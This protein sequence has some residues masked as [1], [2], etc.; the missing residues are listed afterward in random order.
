LKFW[1]FPLA[2]GTTFFRQ[3]LE[4]RGAL[5]STK[6]SET[7]ET[8]TNGTEISLESFRKSKN[9]RISE[10]GTIQPKIQEIPEGK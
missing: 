6:N 7:F 5:R 1:K 9:C 3:F 10:I 2:N 8:G 4:K